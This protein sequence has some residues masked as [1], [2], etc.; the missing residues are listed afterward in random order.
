MLQS[1]FMLSLNRTGV[2]YLKITDV[3]GYMPELIENSLAERSFDF[4]QPDAEGRNIKLA[5]YQG[6]VSVVLVLNRG[7]G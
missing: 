3:G 4:E 1:Y 6:K 7:F 2:N 5:D